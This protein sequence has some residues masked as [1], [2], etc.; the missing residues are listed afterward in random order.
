MEPVLHEHQEV[1]AIPHK[2]L[3]PGKCYVYESK[4]SLLLHRLVSVNKKQ[5]V[6][7]GDNSGAYEVVAVDRVKAYV[8]DRQSQLFYIG[9][10]ILNR[11]MGIPSRWRHGVQC[12]IYRL[13]HRCIRILQKIL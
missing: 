11:L 12:R 4:G 2:R 8:D 9:V 6:F 10:T 1:L 5:C 13:R 3:I 7:W